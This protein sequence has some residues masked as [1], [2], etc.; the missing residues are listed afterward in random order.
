MKIS[1]SVN[2]AW[3]CNKE[4]TFDLRYTKNQILFPSSYKFKEPFDFSQMQLQSNVI[5]LLSYFHHNVSLL[6]NS[7]EV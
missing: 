5:K 7:S 1:K 6:S 3:F 2:N 4:R